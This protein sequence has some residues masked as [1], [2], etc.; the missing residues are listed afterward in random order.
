MRKLIWIITL[1]LAS[2]I[3]CFSQTI[4]L[5]A[6]DNKTWTL[7]EQIDSSMFYSIDTLRFVYNPFA[8]G[9][10]SLS[11]NPQLSLG[12]NKKAELFFFDTLIPISSSASSKHYSLYKRGIYSIDKKNKEFHLSFYVPSDKTISDADY[13]NVN[14]WIKREELVFKILLLTKKQMVLV[15]M[16]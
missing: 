2:I 7:I 11:I 6:I 10:D 14:T 3:V 5:K 15:R 12:D 8:T 1:S 13:E 4:K 16:H 9:V